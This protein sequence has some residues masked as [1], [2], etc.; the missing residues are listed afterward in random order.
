MGEFAV[1]KVNYEK[2]DWYL[3]W[4]YVKP[5]SI[6]VFGIRFRTKDCTPTT[7]YWRT[8]ENRIVG[9]C[10]PYYSDRMEHSS[11]AEFYAD[12]VVIGKTTYDIID[13]EDF[14]LLK[15]MDQ[16]LDEVCRKKK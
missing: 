9:D 11:S 7:M 10:A 16:M 15:Q 6:F 1:Q 13:S 4:V 2:W 12:R 3:P 5:S 8:I 14:P